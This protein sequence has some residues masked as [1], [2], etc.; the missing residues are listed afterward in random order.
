MIDLRLVIVFDMYSPEPLM[1]HGDFVRFGRIG[2]GGVETKGNIFWKFPLRFFDTVSFPFGIPILPYNR[3]QLKAHQ[4]EH[5]PAKPPVER[6]ANARTV[7][8]VKGSLRRAKLRRALDGSAPFRPTGS[9]DGRLR[10]EHETPVR[11]KQKTKTRSL[12]A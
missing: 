7:L 10:R 2:G 1:Y 5:V 6:L 8:A 9:R 3:K 4:Q 11:S 12:T